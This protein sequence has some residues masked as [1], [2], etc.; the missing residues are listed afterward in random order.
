MTKWCETKGWCIIREEV[1]LRWLQLCSTYQIKNS[2]I[3]K[4]VFT[5]II[6]NFQTLHFDK[7][8]IYHLRVVNHSEFFS[9]SLLA[10]DSLMYHILA[11]LSLRV[12]LRGTTIHISVFH[13]SVPCYILF[14]KSLVIDDNI[15]RLLSHAT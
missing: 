11:G 8:T 2:H 14:S 15:L 1:W 5:I 10:P 6:H 3:I 12:F 4:F 13:I 9:H 7:V